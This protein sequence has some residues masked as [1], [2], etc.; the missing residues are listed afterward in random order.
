MARERI[1][2]ADILSSARKGPFAGKLTR[3]IRCLDSLPNRGGVSDRDDVAPGRSIPFG[4]VKVPHQLVVVS[5]WSM[6]I[7][8][9]MARSCSL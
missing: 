8:G 3:D 7:R 2:V 6:T 4:V 1:W 9:C 5:R